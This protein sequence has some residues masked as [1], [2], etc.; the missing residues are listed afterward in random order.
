MD[1][2]DLRIQAIRAITHYKDTE[3]GWDMFERFETFNEK[4]KLFY[5]CSIISTF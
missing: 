1:D 4:E 3:L 5:R 2:P